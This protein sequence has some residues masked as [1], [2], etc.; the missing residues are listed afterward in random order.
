MR[1]ELMG[2]QLNYDKDNVLS[3]MH[4]PLNSRYYENG[5]CLFMLE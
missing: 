4:V 5:I 2:P 1:S 3:S